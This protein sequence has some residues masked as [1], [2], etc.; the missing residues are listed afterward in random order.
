MFTGLFADEG[1]PAADYP[2]DP[3][4]SDPNGLWFF[5]LDRSLH[6]VL[7]LAPGVDPIGACRSVGIEAGAAAGINPGSAHQ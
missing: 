1:F 7:G 2:D 6:P 4:R 3:A 5:N